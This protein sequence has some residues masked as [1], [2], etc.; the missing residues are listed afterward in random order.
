VAWLG[1]CGLGRMGEEG[2]GC[3][4]LDWGESGV[5]GFGQG[6]L[7]KGMVWKGCMKEGLGRVGIYML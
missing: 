3:F 2:F 7:G 5:G 4:G 1:L 6:R